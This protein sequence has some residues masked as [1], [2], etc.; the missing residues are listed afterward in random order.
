MTND[1]GVEVLV[2]FASP[3][4]V[5][6]LHEQVFEGERGVV[7]RDAVRAREP[8]RGDVE[9]GLAQ[10]RFSQ[11]FVRA[12]GLREFGEDSRLPDVMRGRAEPHAC[13]VDAE[14]WLSAKEPNGD[15]VHQC[16]VRNEP[17]WSSLLFE[18]LEHTGWKRHEL[19]QRAIVF[20]G[21]VQERLR[22]RRGAALTSRTPSPARV[23]ALL[24]TRLRETAD[25]GVALVAGREGSPDQQSEQHIVRSW[26][27]GSP[28]QGFGEVRGSGR[29]SRAAA[30]R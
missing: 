5:G 17:R 14:V 25:D 4:R 20:G 27:A 18:Q 11:C 24:L 28:S 19:Q 6:G 2:S 8:R 22:S 9:P 23:F 12:T 7:S 15:V 3:E 29:T 30:R 10:E 13:P 1:G 16:E 21:P 26:G